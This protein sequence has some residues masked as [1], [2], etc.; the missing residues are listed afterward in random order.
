MKLTILTLLTLSAVMF[1]IGYLNN[2]DIKSCMERGH[3]F[4]VCNHTFNR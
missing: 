1:M 3:T 2:A 4:E